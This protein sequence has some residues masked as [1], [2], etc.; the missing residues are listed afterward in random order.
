MIDTDTSTPSDGEQPEQ[1]QCQRPDNP[2]EGP[3]S[4]GGR[5]AAGEAAKYRRRA[6]E[7]E[8]ARD[9]LQA[10]VDRADTAEVQR[11]A[12]EIVV[13]PADLFLTVKL[14]DLR[15]PATGEVDP[16]RVQAAAEAAV[17]D[18]PHWAARTAAA[19]DLARKLRG[20][21]RPSGNQ[22][23]GARSWADVLPRR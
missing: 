10:R 8:Q 20:R 18:R 12:A 1:A 6:Q 5:D 16:A 17:A 14:A 3:E 19:A 9:L 21:V 4:G 2:A 11:L 22:P 7:A 23:S 13:D 15:D